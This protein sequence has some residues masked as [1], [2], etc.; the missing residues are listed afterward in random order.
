MRFFMRLHSRNSPKIR[1]LAKTKQQKS[2]LNAGIYI[3]S[4]ILYY[5]LRFLLFYM[6][7]FASHAFFQSHNFF[8]I[9]NTEICF[10]QQTININ[11]IS[12]L[13]AGLPFCPNSAPDSIEATAKMNKPSMDFRLSNLLFVNNTRILLSKN[14]LYI[15]HD[16][17]NGYQAINQSL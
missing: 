16:H 14:Q 17:V 1:G 4:H 2:I 11:K 12:L 7:L 10:Y 15:Y 8:Y 9:R 13:V 3:F 6:S 5:S